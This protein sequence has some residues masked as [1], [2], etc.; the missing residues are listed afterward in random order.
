M[1][2]W[3]A[4]IVC[5]AFSI[6]PTA[7]VKQTN[8]AVADSVQKAALSEGLAP[9]MMWVKALM[10]R[11]LRDCFDAPDL[12]FVWSDEAS[13][14][15]PWSRARSTPI[16]ITS[17]VRTVNECR[18]DRGLEPLPDPPPEPVPPA[19]PIPPGKEEPAA[20]PAAEPKP[21][22]A[23][24]A[25]LAKA[26][27]KVAPINRD[28]KAVKKLEAKLKK[29]ALAFLKAQVPVIAQALHDAM[30]PTAEKMSKDEAKQLLE[31]SNI[32]WTELGD[33]LE[34]ILAAIAQ[35]GVA[36]GLAQV[37]AKTT[38][39]LL[40]QVNERAVTW[41]EQHAADLVTKMAETTRATLR[42]DLATGIELGMSTDQIAEVIGADYGFS[43]ARAELIARTERAFADVRGNTLAY[44]ASGVVGGLRW[45]VANEG[46]DQVCPDCEQN[47]DVVVPMDP[48]TGEATEAWPS[49]DTECPAHPDCRC[50]VLPVLSQEGEEE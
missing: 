33:D 28:R 21:E 30:P 48:E 15:S 20:A 49:G 40:D 3:L 32:D 38:A 1:D 35:D 14:W 37:G 6:S 44:A 42:G 41:A 22:P 47:D 34:P 23:P 8:R 10:D 19:A 25:K 31:A 5:F 4:R 11:I 2:E 12:E 50:D 27:K 16:D 9:V 36:Q 43:E 18:E 46:D 13:P 24:A 26:A 29:T 17:G 39:D 7:L 45:I